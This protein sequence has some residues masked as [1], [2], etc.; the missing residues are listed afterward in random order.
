MS[1]ASPVRRSRRAALLAVT[2]LLLSGGGVLA[3]SAIT[4][5]ESTEGAHSSKAGTVT[6]LEAQRAAVQDAIGRSDNGSGPGYYA[7][8]SVRFVKNIREAADGVGARVVGDMLYVTT[9]K[10]LQIY[11]ISEPTNPVR[12]GLTTV[13]VEFENEQVPTDGRILGISAQTSSVTTQAAP[14]LAD[15]EA[16]RGCLL[17]FDVRDATAPKLVQSIKSAGD[18]T[19]TC[20]T[21][22]GQTCAYMYGSSGSISDIR[23]ALTDPTPI[24]ESKVNWITA[25]HS[26]LREQG[27]TETLPTRTH[28]QTEV[29]PG[30]LLT[31]SVP[32]MLISVN[33]R[34]GGWPEAPKLLA[35]ASHLTA[36]DGQK[37]FTHSVEWPQAGASKIMMSGGETNARPTCGEN[38]G[39]FSTFTVKGGNSSSPI[40]TYADQYKLQMGDYEDGNTPPGGYKLGCSVHWFQQQ[41][42]FKDGG[43]VALAAYESGT[44]FLDV[45]NNGAITE[46]GFFLP[47]DSSASAVHWAPDGRTLYVIDYLRGIDVI[48]YD[49]AAGRG[50]RAVLQR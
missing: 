2:G 30:Q 36:P 32:Q 11:D 49:G 18:H 38:N 3:F 47:L 37:R 8:D 7:S 16:S 40:F 17:L 10:D 34:D 28:H 9:T 24:V 6:A 41:P 45:A 21:V 44:R 23:A 22:Q 46:Q 42:S 25:L 12:Q 48:T 39:A 31:A 26:Q 43:T 4:P 33:A 1:P 15:L 5:V 13:D 29:R 35:F 20:L 27:W 14:C 19:S 50:G